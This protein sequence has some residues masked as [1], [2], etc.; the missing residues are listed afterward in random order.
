MCRR[1]VR[2]AATFVAAM[3]AMP[4][5]SCPASHCPRIS[6]PASAAKTGWT[7]EKVPK[8]RAGTNRRAVRSAAY[9]IAD[10]SRPAMSAY[11]S[12]HPASRPSIPSQVSTGRYAA[13]ATRL[14]M[15]GACNPGIRCP[16]TRLIR[17]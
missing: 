1:A 7:L 3:I 17:M 5:H 14:P 16:A 2:V 4:T 11:P 9:G 6:I 12:G 15:A 8:N 13:A 10:E